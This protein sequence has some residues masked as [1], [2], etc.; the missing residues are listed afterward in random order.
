MSQW[1]PLYFPVILVCL[2]SCLNSQIPPQNSLLSEKTERSAH[3]AV[4]RTLVIE[5]NTAAPIFIIFYYYSVIIPWEL[6]QFS[7][8]PPPPP[9][10]V[11]CTLLPMIKHIFFV[12][13]ACVFLKSCK[14]LKLFESW[15]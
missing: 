1:F 13:L 6:D 7:N 10:S 5:P 3:K 9:C 2:T 4:K 8:P 11:G 12:I 14:D 15:N